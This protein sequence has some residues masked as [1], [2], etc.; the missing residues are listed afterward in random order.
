MP[1]TST[2]PS[3]EEQ[4]E[5][6]TKE[7]ELIKRPSNQQPKSEGVEDGGAGSEGE[8]SKGVKRKREEVHAE[9]DAGKSTDKK[10]V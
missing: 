4:K 5:P 6:G 8:D 3:T 10:R 7:G 1:G 9:E 2:E